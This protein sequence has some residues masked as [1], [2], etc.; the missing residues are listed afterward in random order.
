MT[1]KIINSE[2]C[3]LHNI[4]LSLG[5]PYTIHNLVKHELLDIVHVQIIHDRTKDVRNGFQASTA[6]IASTVLSGFIGLL[7]VP[8]RAK[9]TYDID[10]D[11]YLADGR[12]VEIWSDDPQFIKFCLPLMHTK[13]R[14]DKFRKQR[15]V[16]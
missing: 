12:V 1:T 16:K 9:V 5:K 3:G 13:D 2:E 14:R 10:M 11:L 15:G 6:T 8:Y 4:I 7:T